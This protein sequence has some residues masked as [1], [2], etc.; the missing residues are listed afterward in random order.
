MSRASGRPDSTTAPMM[1]TAIAT[2]T[3][4]STPSIRSRRLAGMSLGSRPLSTTQDCWKNNC[5][6]AMLV[7]MLADSRIRNVAE[8]RPP[9]S[10]QSPPEK[11]RATSLQSGLAISTSGTNTRLNAA[12]TSATRSHA[13]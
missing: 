7:P 13:Q 11:A 3:M 8:S 6:G 5:H 12:I 1:I 9:G 4:P 10:T 2:T